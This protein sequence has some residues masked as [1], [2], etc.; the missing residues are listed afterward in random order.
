MAVFFLLV[1]LEIKREMLDGQLSTWPRRI[2]PGHRRRRR[3]GRA[4]ADLSSR[5]TAD[6][7]RH[8]RGWAIPAATDIAFALGV[9]ALLGP[10]VPA[11]LKCS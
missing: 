8:L 1:G 10:R 7:R 3:H 2:L 9:L 6:S 5:S 4:G 11:S